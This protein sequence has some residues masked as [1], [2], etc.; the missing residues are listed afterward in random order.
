MLLLPEM[1]PLVSPLDVLVPSP[2]LF[3]P[4]QLEMEELMAFPGRPE[5]PEVPPRWW[6][7]SP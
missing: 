2:D 3:V 5:A 4:F 7:K 6:E 1:V